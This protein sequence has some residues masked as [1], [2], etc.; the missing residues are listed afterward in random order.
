MPQELEED[1]TERPARARRRSRYERPRSAIIW[2]VLLLGMILGMG[3]GLYYA[4]VI[5]PVAE[6]D[7]DPW[8]L[9]QTSDDGIPL[10]DRDAYVIAILMGY[11]YDL[12]PAQAIERLVDLRLPGDPVQY[13]ADLACRLV[14]DGYL[15]TN[16]RRNAVRSLVRFYQDRGKVSCADQY[17]VIDP[18]PDVSTPPVVVLSTPL[19]P[20]TKTPVPQ[21]VLPP[22]PTPLDRVFVPTPV[23]QQDFELVVVEAFCS[24]NIPGVIEVFV[25]NR[26]GEGVPGMRI[27]AR[28]EDETSDFVTGLKPERG[29]GYADFDM[30]P[31]RSYIV[32]MP[33]LSD[34]SPNPLV[35]S[36]CFDQARGET[37]V[38]SYRLVFVGG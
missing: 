38:Q 32:E 14:Q 31:G 15:T 16:S 20:A 12:D 21:D 29:P 7:I 37:T 8:Q 9:M 6:A 3:G 36:E 19:P 10:A 34:P 18:A 25:R 13:V 11:S 5:A 33:G 24:V 17:I 26:A 28:G 1:F 2:T 4:W 23:P 27:R 30:Q 35:A 22:S